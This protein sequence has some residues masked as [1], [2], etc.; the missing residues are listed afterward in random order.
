MHGAGTYM[1]K[2]GEKREGIW[3]NGKRIEWTSAVL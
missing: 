1:N 2:N 3:E